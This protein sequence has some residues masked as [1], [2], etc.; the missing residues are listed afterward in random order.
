MS[1]V[2][3]RHDAEK[4]RRGARK[5]A[6]S[7]LARNVWRVKIVRQ[8]EVGPEWSDLRKHVVGG[9]RS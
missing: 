7:T 1:E 5:H 3:Q 8:A 6:A 2:C 9:S 4:A